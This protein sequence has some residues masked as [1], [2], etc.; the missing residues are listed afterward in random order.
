MAGTTGSLGS[1]DVLVA[2]LGN[3][4][5]IWMYQSRVIIS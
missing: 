5:L 4:A 3:P 2:E 1:K